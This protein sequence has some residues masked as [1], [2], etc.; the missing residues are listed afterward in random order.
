[1]AADGCDLLTVAKLVPALLHVVV[2][3]VE[4]VVWFTVTAWCVRRAA[5]RARAA[6]IALQAT[7]GDAR[8]SALAKMKELLAAR[9]ADVIAANDRDKHDSTRDGISDTLFKV[10]GPRRVQGVA[11]V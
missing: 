11:A 10:C 4:A 6:A 3:V 5:R 7:S 1:M 9:E 8:N 2:V